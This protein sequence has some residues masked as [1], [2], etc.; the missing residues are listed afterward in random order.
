MQNEF[1]ESELPVVLGYDTDGL[2]DEELVKP[3]VN[4][5]EWVLKHIP[6]S[7]FHI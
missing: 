5:S 6:R 2:L 1:F 3:I 7:E 4:D